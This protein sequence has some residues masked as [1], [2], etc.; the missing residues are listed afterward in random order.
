MPF[1]ST[2][3]PL[4]TQAAA[5]AATEGRED[6]ATSRARAT[7]VP[8]RPKLSGT[9]NQNR[10]PELRAP[11]AANRVASARARPIRRKRV[12]RIPAKRPPS[13]EPARPAPR[14]GSACP[15]RAVAPA[16]S[17]CPRVGK[18]GWAPP[19]SQPPGRTMTSSRYGRSE[20]NQRFAAEGCASPGSTS[21]EAARQ[22]AAA[23]KATAHAW[24]HSPRA[25]RLRE[26]S[27]VEPTGPP[28]S[29]CRG[30]SARGPGSW[31]R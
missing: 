5:R 14:S 2:L 17:R 26:S 1:V 7:P 22:A 24:I 19:F 21:R 10:D 29:P 11:M 8:A 6:A 9:G 23:A 3:A 13:A 12:K 16:S 31:R 4:A 30:R 18:S 20:S 25:G 28:V 15:V 27:A